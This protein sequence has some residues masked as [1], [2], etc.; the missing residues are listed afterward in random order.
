MSIYKDQYTLF[1]TNHQFVDCIVQ[2]PRILVYSEIHDADIL[3]EARHRGIVFENPTAAIPKEAA[4]T[5]PAALL[6]LYKHLVFRYDDYTNFRIPYFRGEKIVAISLDVL[7][8]PPCTIYNYIS[9]ASILPDDQVICGEKIQAVAADVVVGAPSSLSFNPN[10]PKFSKELKTVGELSDLSKYRKIFVF[11]HDL[12]EFCAKFGRGGGDLSDKVLITHNSDHEIKD[13]VATTA[14]KIHFAQNCMIKH[15]KLIPLPIGIENT[16]WFDH[17]VFHRIRKMRIPKTKFCYFYFNLDT[18]SSRRDCVAALAAGAAA[19]AAHPTPLEWNTRKNK[20]DYF[21]EL[22]TH[23]YA[24]CPR[25]NGLDTHR[26]WEC[27]YLDVIPIIVEGD[28]LKIENLPI[29]KLKQWSDFYE[30]MRTFED[31]FAATE[32]QKITMDYYLQ[33]IEILCQQ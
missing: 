26:I 18:H 28:D 7:G 32:L 21:M 2:S 8:I 25:G 10:N 19:T 14:A 12:P 6:E 3:E 13:L 1:N 31:S 22:A 5:D 20:E 23:K 9:S 4:V 11:T 17:A 33:K 27:L 29:I 24:I 30:Y 16:Q 15:E